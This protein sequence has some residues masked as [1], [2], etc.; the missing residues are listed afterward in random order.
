MSKNNEERYEVLLNIPN[1]GAE[2]GAKHGALLVEYWAVTHDIPVV[3]GTLIEAGYL[4]DTLV[5]SFDVEE[6]PA[7][8]EAMSSLPAGSKWRARQYNTDNYFGNLTEIMHPLGVCS[9][10]AHSIFSEEEFAD[11]VAEQ[12]PI[13]TEVVNDVSAS[14]LPSII[15]HPGIGEE[16]DFAVSFGAML[17][18]WAV[19]NKLTRDDI[20]KRAELYK[21]IASAME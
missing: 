11:D 6:L 9:E 12:P 2:H 18:D 17:R 21:F 7:L 4:G 16:E 10:I 14:P 3:E 19:R 1:V 13:N 20:I 15:K 8:I 5:A